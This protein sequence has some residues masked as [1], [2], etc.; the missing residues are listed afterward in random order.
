VS[1]ADRRRASIATA[2]KQHGPI[3][4]EEPHAQLP[5][6][7]ERER[8]LSRAR[9][10]VAGQSAPPV[11]QSEAS[12]AAPALARFSRQQVT[13]EPALPPSRR[14]RLQMFCSGVGRGFI[15]IGLE[16]NGHVQLVSHESPSGGEGRSA[17][18]PVLRAYNYIGAL[19]EWNCPVCRL[20]PA[21]AEAFGCAC[22]CFS[23][24]LHC[25]GRA[26]G[27]VYCACGA[28]GEANF[29]R[30]PSLAVRGHATARTPAAPLRRGGS[31]LLLTGP[32]REPKPL[33]PRCLR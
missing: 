23:D 32:P 30:V 16:H 27:N 14:V 6:L 29:R 2:I 22:A 26:D 4:E 21:G 12:Y 1:A 11:P 20:A 15:G 9:A 10:V 8:I 3:V 7:A 33:A 17:D 24:V 19:R 31:A 13:G 28:F 18:A 5:A 25:G